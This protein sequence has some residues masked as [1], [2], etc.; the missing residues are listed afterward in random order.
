VIGLFGCSYDGVRK[1]DNAKVAQ[2]FSAGLTTIID[3]EPVKRAT[4]GHEL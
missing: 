3:P 2:H 1:A 4:E